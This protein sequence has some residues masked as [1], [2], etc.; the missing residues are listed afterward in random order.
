[1]MQ[2]LS[3]NP[4]FKAQSLVD[5]K[6]VGFRNDRDDIHDLAQLLHNNHIDGAKTVT[7]RVDEEETAVNSGIL[8]VTV[9]LSG[10]FLSEVGRVL[11]LDVLDDRIPTALV[12]NLVTISRR[13]DDVQPKF[14]P[15]LRDDMR[16][17]LDFSRLP[18]R[19]I[20]LQTTLRVNEMRSEDGV[21]E[22][23][24]PKSSLP[25][26]NDIELEA[27]LEQLMF[28]LAG[29]GVE[30]DVGRRANLFYLGGHW[31]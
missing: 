3:P 8:D 15:I 25:D 21:D 31:A 24:L 12:V 13:V 27:T 23:A 4:I 7:G 6:R 17:S 26:D 2:K 20:M 9:P 19:L 10:E 30:A 11:V 1:M 16:N 28:D 22:S 29:D 18:Y 5:S 14:D